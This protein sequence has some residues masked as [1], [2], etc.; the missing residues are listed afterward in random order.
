[1]K[2]PVRLLVPA[3]LHEVRLALVRPNGPSSSKPASTSEKA[4]EDCLIMILRL[5]RNNASVDH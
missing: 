3:R 5:R 4:G 1:L 2:L